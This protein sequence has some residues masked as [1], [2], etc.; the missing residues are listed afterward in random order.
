MN[1]VDLKNKLLSL[2]VF[3]DNE[4]LDKYVDLI[5]ENRNRKAEKFVTQNHH[6]I[7]KCYF[8]L[9]NLIVDNSRENKVV[10]IF[11][12]HVLAHCY[13]VL[14]SKENIFKYYNMCAIYKVMH[15]KDYSS[16]W[17]L[18]ENL[19]EVQLAYESARK[20]A[21]KYN[22]M[23]IEK[24]RKK[25]ANTLSKK[26]TREA[27]SKGLKEYRKTHPFS[28]EHRKKLSES[29]MGNDNWGRHD[30][31][32][33]PCY[34]IELKTG[35]EHHFSSYKEGGL[36]WFKKYHPFGDT[37][38]QVTF[39][40][41]IIAMIEGKEVSWGKGKQGRGKEDRQIMNDYIAWFREEGGDKNEKVSENKKKENSSRS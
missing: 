16:M 9:N 12:D 10:L 11:K 38:V 39:Q 26:E 1:K 21:F 23:H 4:Y 20:V 40:R 35:E 17:E 14:A 3:I 18:V 7:P 30:Q 28:E 13:I 24:S 41:K 8:K 34:C 5:I 6:I 27:I 29:A 37:Y 36:W 15:S 33:I 31:A 25:H 32:S 22:P 2:D 19:D